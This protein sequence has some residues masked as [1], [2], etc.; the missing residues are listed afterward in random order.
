[1]E[2]ERNQ[3][4]L[5]A[6]DDGYENSISLGKASLCAVIASPYYVLVGLALVRHAISAALASR[7]I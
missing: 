2:N 5:M 3:G 6:I 1:M 7:L 4:S